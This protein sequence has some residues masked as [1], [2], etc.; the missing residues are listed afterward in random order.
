MLEMLSRV[1]DNYEMALNQT[2]SLESDSESEPR[3][4]NITDRACT[5][6]QC[7]KLKLAIRKRSR[8]V[9]ALPDSIGRE[10]L[11]TTF[12]SVVRQPCL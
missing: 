11:K 10:L 6:S 4:V 2:E 3:T 1:T 7:T 9:E 8:C 12:Y 5:S